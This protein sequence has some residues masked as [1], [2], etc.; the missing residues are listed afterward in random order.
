MGNN[1]ENQVVQNRTTKGGE[2]KCFEVRTKRLVQKFETVFPVSFRYLT[3]VIRLNKWTF[4]EWFVDVQTVL[5]NKTCLLFT[6]NKKKY[7]NL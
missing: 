5:V 2:Q 6:K 7:L 1:D 4:V 3:F